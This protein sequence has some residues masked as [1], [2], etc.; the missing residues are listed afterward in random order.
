MRTAPRWLAIGLLLA[1][2]AAVT[3]HAENEPQT[4]PSK[5]A[6]EAAPKEETP[7]ASVT[8]IAPREAHGVLGR[9]V[10][11]PTNE[12]MGRMVDV[13]VD[14]TGTVRAAV[15]DF[16]GFLGVGSR[17]IVVDWNALHFG[18]VADKSDNITLELTKAQVAAAPEYKEDKPIVVLGAAGSLQPLDEH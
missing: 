2:F 15:I 14:R 16:G 5:A 1:A 3:S 8:I 11:S 18:R 6:K 12:D 10:R 4:E 7:P 13:I 17:K 9:D